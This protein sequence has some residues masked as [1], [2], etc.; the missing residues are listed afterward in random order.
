MQFV[1]QLGFTG[2]I[3]RERQQT[4]HGATGMTRRQCGKQPVPGMTE[5]LTR[6]Q[7]VAVNQ[8]EQRHRLP[9]QGMDDMTI[10][11]HMTAAAAIGTTLWYASASQRQ[12]QC[13]AEQAFQPV[14]I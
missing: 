7:L 10:I 5:C 1:S 9:A 8:I 2:A 11:D 3:A 13:A 4:D 12:H 14:V 6:E